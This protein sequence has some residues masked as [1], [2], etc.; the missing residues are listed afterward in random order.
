MSSGSTS[1]PRART[2]T[3]G[4][5]TA[6]A[7]VSADPEFIGQIERICLAIEGGAHHAE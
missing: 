6:R 5:A 2:V 7:R 3:E 4:V 1:L